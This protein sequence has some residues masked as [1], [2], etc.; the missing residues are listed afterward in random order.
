MVRSSHVARGRRKGVVSNRFSFQIQCGHHAKSRHDE[1]E[2]NSDPQYLKC[3]VGSWISD[4]Y[5]GP[6][7]LTKCSR[8]I[9]E[10]RYNK[11]LMPNA[12]PPNILV[13][14]VPQ[15]LHD[16]RRL[17]LDDDMTPWETPV[18]QLS[19]HN[20]P[21]KLNDNG[22][23]CHFFCNMPACNLTSYPLVSLPTGSTFGIFRCEILFHGAGSFVRLASCGH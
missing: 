11:A 19:Q 23:V 7:S 6:V 22:Q 5:L 10:S 14:C 18:P 1:D 16:H 17:H 2:F 21:S 8:R 15:D 12:F 3:D 13:G 9:V 4:T 20:N